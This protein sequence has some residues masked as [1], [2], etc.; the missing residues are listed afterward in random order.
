[1]FGLW[2][3]KDIWFGLALSRGGAPWAEQAGQLSR[4]WEPAGGSRQSAEKAQETQTDMQDG[5]QNVD[6][7]RNAQTSEKSERG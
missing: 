1:M 4:P 5:E 2:G 3:Q 6:K 7:N